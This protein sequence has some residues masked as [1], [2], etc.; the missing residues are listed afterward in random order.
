MLTMISGTY[1][2]MVRYVKNVRVHSAA[3]AVSNSALF[4]G[5]NRIEDY[6][7]KRRL[8][9][10]G[11]CARSKQPIADLM[12]ALNPTNASKIYR[13]TNYAARLT[14]DVIDVIPAKYLRHSRGV[15]FLP[16]E[17]LRTC[18]LNRSEWKATVDAALEQQARSRTPAEEVK[19]VQA[20]LAHAPP[21]NLLPF[22]ELKD[23]GVARG[24]QLRWP[25]RVRHQVR[26]PLP[27][28]RPATC[29]PHEPLH[30][31]TSLFRRCPTNSAISSGPPPAPSPAPQDLKTRN[32]TEFADY[33]RCPQRP[34]PAR[35]L[36]Q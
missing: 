4:E 11:H 12:L 18:M 21:K 34:E 24:R 6:L 30:S 31:S 10:A 8:T 28:V 7:L 2:Q 33:I 13:A 19:R 1:T 25:P 32:A 3:T 20:R 16:Q 27:P 23:R 14:T 29:R 36:T 22:D 35:H 15:A 17:S 26:S 9:F 5:F